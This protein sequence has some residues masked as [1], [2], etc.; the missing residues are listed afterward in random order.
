[1][2]TSLQLST[3]VHLFKIYR[4]YFQK[5]CHSGSPI[6]YPPMPIFRKKKLTN[7][8]W[9]Y[10]KWAQ[11]SWIETTFVFKQRPCLSL[12]AQNHTLSLADIPLRTLFFSLISRKSLNSDVIIWKLKFE[13]SGM[14]RI[15][16]IRF[17][18]SAF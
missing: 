8:W 12:S 14:N 5:Q 15:R 11:A 17:D 6:R 9:K 10:L 4:T 13:Q 1:M 18:E 3:T 7:T 16:M 2:I